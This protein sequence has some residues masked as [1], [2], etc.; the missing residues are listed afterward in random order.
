MIRHFTELCKLIFEDLTDLTIFQDATDGF[1]HFG[2]KCPRCGASGMLSPYN[3]YFR[4]LVSHKDGETIVYRVWIR[5]L[6]CESCCA[7]HA[8]LPDIIIPYNSYSLRFKFT[9]LIA[10]F[11]RKTTVAKICEQFGIVVSTLY[12]W[13]V[14]LLE[15]KALLL[16]ALACRKEPTLDFLHRLFDSTSL[17]DHLSSFFYR[18]AFSFLQ[19]RLSTT[20]SSLPP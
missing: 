16:G 8:L 3:G 18:Y 1:N 11:K 17:S 15:H 2:K 13:K 7:T 10:Y 20:T 14:L 4:Y 5:R 6:K 9:V 12:A 19:K